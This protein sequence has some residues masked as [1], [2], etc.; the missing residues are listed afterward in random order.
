[1]VTRALPVLFFQDI[2]HCTLLFKVMCQMPM[3]GMACKVGH[4]A[5]GEESNQTL[6]VKMRC[7]NLPFCVTNFEAFVV[8][9]IH[10]SIRIG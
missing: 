9:L 2:M 7:P 6:Q 1:M 5:W 3:L 10:G 4:M 8:N